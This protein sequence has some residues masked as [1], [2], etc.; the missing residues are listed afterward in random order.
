MN[1]KVKEQVAETGNMIEEKT[2]NAINQVQDVTRKSYYAY[3]GMWRM[4]YD[5]AIET[6][7]YSRRMVDKAIE[8]GEGVERM[9][10]EEVQDTVTEMKTEVEA[11]A[12]KIQKRLKKGLRRSERGLE[13]QIETVLER[14]EVPTQNTLVELN[15][16]IEMLNKKIDNMIL[17]QNQVVIE[18]PMPRYDTLTAK[19]IVKRLDE[20]TLEELVNVKQ[21]EMAHE[22]RVTVL[23]EVDRR[24]DAMPIA[25]YDA[26]T[27]DEIEPMLST[28]DT[29]ELK[30]VAKYEAAHEN[31]VTLLRAI[32]SELAA[33]ETAVA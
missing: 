7:T 4:I 22:N 11:R 30:A 20:L 10:I 15:E 24:L 16:R 3:L 33:R 9:A 29:A 28:L 19:D 21:Y 2:G 25:R 6:V 32:D 23:R 26:L 18:Q 27:V 5:G 31:R 14:L 17:A 1:I 13:D 12:N 8:R